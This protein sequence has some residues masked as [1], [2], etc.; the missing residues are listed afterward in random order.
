MQRSNDGSAFRTL[1]AT[2]KLT[3]QRNEFDLEAI[4]SEAGVSRRA[5]EAVLSNFLDLGQTRVYLTP[6]SRLHM[7]MEI[8]RKGHID[9]AAKALTWREFEQFAED[10]LVE[11]GFQT[12]KNV[13]VKGDGRAWQID[14]LGLRGELILAVDCKHWNST[15]Y[16]SRFKL[17]ADH[18][19]RATIHLH[20]VKSENETP[21][22]QELQALAVILALRE[23]PSQFTRDTVLISVEKFPRFLSEV[24]PY[25]ENLPFVTS[26]STLE[27]N[28]MNQSIESRSSQS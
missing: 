15:G 9:R 18:Q 12:E 3:A 24:T 14:V 19:R 28:P 4:A 23:P 20:R 5:A 27:E 11:S 6:T 2:L 13:R 10:C 8:A 17:A 16:L 21:G 22:N 26:N 25:D 1:S 7:A